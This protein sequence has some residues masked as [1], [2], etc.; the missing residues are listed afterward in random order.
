M[1]ELYPEVIYA[2]YASSAPVLFRE[3]FYEYAIA[4][5]NGIPRV[6][7]GSQD[8]VDGWKKAIGKLQAYGVTAR[9]V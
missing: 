8:C 1:R 9:H 6:A 2:A 7:G 5:D 4:V 3:D